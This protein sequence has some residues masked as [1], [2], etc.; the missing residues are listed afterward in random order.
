MVSMWWAA[1]GER[2]SNNLIQTLCGTETCRASTDNKD[3]DVAIYALIS[4]NFLAG[5]GRQ[6]HGGSQ[7]CR[8]LCR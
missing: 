7:T 4:L 5:D 8:P 2:A 6:Q 1:S 3:V